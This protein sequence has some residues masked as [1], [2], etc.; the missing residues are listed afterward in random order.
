MIKID[1]SIL[2]TGTFYFNTDY[3]YYFNYIDIC[4]Y[5]YFEYR[6]L[7]FK[8]RYKYFLHAIVFYICFIFTSEPSINI[9]FDEPF[10]SRPR[11]L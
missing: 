11:N 10:T 1:T 8:Y 3:C 4:I 7:Y 9:P 2:N 5:L 6:Y